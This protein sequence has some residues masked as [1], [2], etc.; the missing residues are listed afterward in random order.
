[1]IKKVREKSIRLLK[2]EAGGRRVDKNHPVYAQIER[3][4]GRQTAGY[5]GE[6]ALDYYLTF[7]PDDKYFIFHGLRL[8]DPKNRYFQM[9]SY[10]FSLTHGLILESKYISGELEFDEKSNQ[11]IRKVADGHE[12]MGDPI[13]QVERHKDQM[14]SWMER[15]LGKVVPITGQVV[16]T[17]KNA[18]LKNV[19]PSTMKKVTFLTNLPNRIKTI[20]E[21]LPNPI[22]TEKELRKAARILNQ[23]HTPDQFAFMDFFKLSIKEIITGVI[24]PECSHTPMIRRSAKWICQKCGCKSKNAHIGSLKDYSLLIGNSITNKQAKEFLHLSSS[25]VTFQI[26]QSMNLRH[27]G[28]KKG[29]VYFFD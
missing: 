24:C 5:K 22:L 28:T 18:V 2:M 17:N 11:L 19:S 15:F 27:T 8:E 16:L 21:N 1:M 20:N 13:S 9:D 6:C 26:L 29:R 25:S 3:E 12:S 10:L 4:L 14:R 23:K 7:L